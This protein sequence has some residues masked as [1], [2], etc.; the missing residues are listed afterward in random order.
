MNR[1]LFRIVTVKGIYIYIVE[2]LTLRFFVTV[3]RQN[4]VKYLFKVHET[5]ILII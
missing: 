3:G 4:D 5:Y 1:V 2:C